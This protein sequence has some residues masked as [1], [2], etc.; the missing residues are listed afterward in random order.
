MTASIYVPKCAVWHYLVRMGLEIKGEENHPRKG[1]GYT[2]WNFFRWNRVRKPVYLPLK[3][4]SAW[5]DSDGSGE[6]EY[7]VGS[8]SGV[9]HEAFL[10]VVAAPGDFLGDAEA[11]E[12]EAWRL[13]L[14]AED[15]RTEIEGDIK[16]HRN[17]AVRMLKISWG[18]ESSCCGPQKPVS[19][20][21]TAA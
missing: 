17:V 8:I 10:D 21:R 1:A 5:D 4:V 6:R 16:H 20:K 12:V 7:E 13:R 14:E 3:M 9:L 18:A 15:G 19:A 11:R 2:R